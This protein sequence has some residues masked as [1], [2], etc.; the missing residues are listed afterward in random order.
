[1]NLAAGEVRGRLAVAEDE[2]LFMAP[3][4]L[5]EDAWLESALRDE[6]AGLVSPGDPFCFREFY[7]VVEFR[8]ERVVI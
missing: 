1:M 3:A 7:L 6:D 5:K 2:E 4:D 8:Q